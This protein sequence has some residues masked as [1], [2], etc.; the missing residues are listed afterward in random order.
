MRQ[1]VFGKGFLTGN[2]E[3][4][5]LR[6]QK[7]EGLRKVLLSTGAGAAALRPLVAPPMSAYGLVSYP[8]GVILGP[9]GFADQR[10]C[11]REDLIDCVRQHGGMR[12]QR[13]DA[14]QCVIGRVGTV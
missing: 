9:T 13:L 4:L 2:A 14:T 11:R 6:S 12:D 3:C 1:R 7:K 10:D 8:R 5:T